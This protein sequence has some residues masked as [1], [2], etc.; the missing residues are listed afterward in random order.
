MGD[1]MENVKEF[2][3]IQKQSKNGIAGNSLCFVI[4]PNGSDSTVTNGTTLRFGGQ[5][6]R[7]L[8]FRSGNI[9][10]YELKSGCLE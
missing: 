1:F 3:I 9:Q 7:L 4:Y 6:P 2:D 8:A 10:E 5:K